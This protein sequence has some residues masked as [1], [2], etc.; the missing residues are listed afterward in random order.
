MAVSKAFLQE[1]KNH[2][3][4]QLFKQESNGEGEVEVT[5]VSKEGT[6]IA[7][8]TT[9]D[10]SDDLK[11]KSKSTI[12]KNVSRATA[13]K[14][15]ADYKNSLSQKKGTTIEALA[16][17][18]AGATSIG[19]RK[20]SKTRLSYA[21]GGG[22]DFES[23]DRHSGSNSLI[24]TKGGA[25]RRTTTLRPLL[26]ELMQRYVVNDMTRPAAPLRFRTGRF[27]NSTTVLDIKTV[28]RKNLPDTLSIY[29]TYMIEPYS[30][31]DPAISNYRGLSSAGRNPQR[32][33]GQALQNAARDIISARYDL[34]I[35]QGAY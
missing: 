9:F 2:T 19:H 26:Q 31:F 25:K 30:V 32:I 21:L 12:R 7:T 28:K 16:L 29:Y 6:P 15:L 10:I 17:K 27:A 35:R 22:T 18:L 8:K 5:E 4:E 14:L 11:E 20:Q 24:E 3:G 13:R 33:I 23:T 34:N 1:I